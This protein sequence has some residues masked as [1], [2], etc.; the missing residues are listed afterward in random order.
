MK[1]NLNTIL[2]VGHDEHLMATRQWI[3]QSRGYKVLKVTHLP[4]IGALPREPAV[5]LLILC[6]SLS[7]REAATVTAVAK[8]RWPEIRT[9]SLG[10]EDGRAPGGMLGQ[11]L[12]TVDGSAKLI[13]QVDGAL[14]DP[15]I[16]ADRAAS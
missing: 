6:Q 13:S 4:R 5:R 15:S 9:L 2:L 11:L 14:S 7:S 16:I 8:L 3:L 10:A 12:H 1:T